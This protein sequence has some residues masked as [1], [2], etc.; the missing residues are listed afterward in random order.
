MSGRY[1]LHPEDNHF[2][3]DKNSKPL[4]ASY[5]KVGVVCIWQVSELLQNC[6]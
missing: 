4:L 3:V 2:D 6:E 1:F 5:F